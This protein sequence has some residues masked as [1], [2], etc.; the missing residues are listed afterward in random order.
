M[1]PC[2]TTSS[3]RYLT[4]RRPLTG[5]NIWHAEEPAVSALR[6]ASLNPLSFAPLLCRLFDPIDLRGDR[7]IAPSCFLG[8]RHG[9]SVVQLALSADSDDAARGYRTHGVHLFR[10]DAAH[11]SEVMATRWCCPGRS[12]KTNTAKRRVHS[13][14]RQGA[15]YD[16]I[17]TM[18]D[19]WLRPLMHRFSQM[20]QQRPL[21]KDV[22]G[23]V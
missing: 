15:C 10:S 8:L 5:L 1:R 22:L 13:L 19:D 7:P 17:P 2:R 23:P 20:L 18:R 16:L 3:R 14:F 4:Q 6:S 9:P 12:L 11:H 21:F